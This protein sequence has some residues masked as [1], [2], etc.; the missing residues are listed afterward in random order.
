MRL[1]ISCWFF[2][3]V[4]PPRVKALANMNKFFPPLSSY[5]PPYP[6]ATDGHIPNSVLLRELRK[7]AKDQE[8]AE[9]WK[10]KPLT[11]E[12]L[13]ALAAADRTVCL[14]FGSAHD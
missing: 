5:E 10:L 3:F 11:A 6:I 1:G 13:A 2:A 12:Q 14:N 8:R 4:E 7:S 9:E